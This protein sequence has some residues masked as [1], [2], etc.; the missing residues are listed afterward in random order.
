ML[1]RSDKKEPKDK[2]D[3]Y[4]YPYFLNIKTPKEIPITS[5]GSLDDL[6]KDFGG[7]IGY[8]EILVTGQG[9]AAKLNKPM[10]NKYFLKTNSLCVDKDNKKVPRS[11]Y[12]NNV[13][14]GNIPFISSMMNADFSDLRG[15]IPGIMS[16][17][18]ALNPE[19]IFDSFKLANVPACTNIKM[20]TIDIDNN[21]K[22]EIGRAHV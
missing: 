1:F 15:L 9:R 4:A 22:Y 16:N 10:G 20:Q 8:A 13:P 7:I 3:P 12:I 17:L 21:I 6:A 5:T 11:I 2:R 18:G 19:Y 14:E